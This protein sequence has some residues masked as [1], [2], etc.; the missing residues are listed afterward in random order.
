MLTH[1]VLRHFLKPVLAWGAPGLVA[2]KHRGENR[3]RFL[4]GKSVL[5]AVGVLARGQEPAGVLGDILGFPT[6][7]A[8]SSWSSS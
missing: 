5:A 4:E 8:W 2:P 3:L 1:F 6:E 7:M